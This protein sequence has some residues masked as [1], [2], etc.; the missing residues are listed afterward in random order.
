MGLNNRCEVLDWFHLTQDRTQWWA[1]VKMVMDLRIA[2]KL[3][4]VERLSP[5]Q[6]I[7]SILL[8][9]QHPDVGRE[10]VTSLSIQGMRELY[11]Q[12]R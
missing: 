10:S 1:L 4:P 5:S 2:C 6:G 7:C 3:G 9:Y 11:F 8:M 12:C